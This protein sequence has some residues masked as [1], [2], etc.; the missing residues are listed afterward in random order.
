MNRTIVYPQLDPDHS[1]E[2]FKMNKTSFG[3]EWVGLTS[4]GFGIA[5]YD[6]GG[7]MYGGLAIDDLRYALR[8]RC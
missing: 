8:T 5:K 6:D 7:N 2:D 3:R 1:Q 4:I